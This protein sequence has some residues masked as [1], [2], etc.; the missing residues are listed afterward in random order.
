MLCGR[1]VDA[2]LILEE[3]STLLNGSRCGMMPKKGAKLFNI[4]APA[5]INRHK[6]GSCR[7]PPGC[8]EI[9]FTSRAPANDR[10]KA[11]VFLHDSHTT[12][13]TPQDQGRYNLNIVRVA[14]GHNEFPQ[15]L[16]RRNVRKNIP[17]RR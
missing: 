17:L 5:F 14:M 13:P 15:S 1:K 3:V 6:H 4:S 12:P 16:R 8:L 10:S 7:W 9:A 11:L 2:F